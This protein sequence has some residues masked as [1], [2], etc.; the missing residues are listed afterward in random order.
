M[1]ATQ[2]CAHPF[3]SEVG[4]AQ[5]ADAAVILVALGSR[6]DV[7]PCVRLLCH[8]G[9]AGCP[10]AAHPP[11]AHLLH[12]CAHER[13][14]IWPRCSFHVVTH[15]A[16]AAWIATMLR[17]AAAHPDDAAAHAVHTHLLPIPVSLGCE[18]SVDEHT[19]GVPDNVRTA[20]ALRSHSRI[21]FDA[22]TALCQRLNAHGMHGNGLL[23]ANLFALET[24]LVAEM[25]ALPVAILS[26]YFMP[27]ALDADALER[28]LCHHRP[29]FLTLLQRG[30]TTQR[31][32]TDMR[33]RMH[34]PLA[35]RA[36]VGEDEAA[37]HDVDATAR[38][39]Q[40]SRTATMSWE[41]VCHWAYPLLHAP[42]WQHL[43]SPGMPCDASVWAVQEEE[44]EEEEE[45]ADVCLAC[46]PGAVCHC[47]PGADALMAALA[48]T[49]PYRIPVLYGCSQLLA[50]R[51][52]ALPPCAR[53]MGCWEL[54]A[55][56]PTRVAATEAAPARHRLLAVTFGSMAQ[57]G[58]FSSWHQAT[59]TT[60]RGDANQLTQAHVWAV[61]THLI[62]RA[63]RERRAHTLFLSHGCAAMARGFR[64]AAA[65][66]AQLLHL[67]TLQEADAARFQ[68][69]GVFNTATAVLHHVGVGTTH[70]ALAAGVH[71]VLAPCMFDQYERADV[72]VE[73]KL[74]PADAV[75]DMARVWTDACALCA[76]VQHTTDSALDRGV[77]HRKD[78][79][80]HFALT[81]QCEAVLSNTPAA[82]HAYPELCRLARAIVACFTPE[83]TC[84]VPLLPAAQAAVHALAHEL[85]SVATWTA[86]HDTFVTP[87]GSFRTFSGSWS[88][89][90]EDVPPLRALR[91]LPDTIRQKL[92]CCVLPNGTRALTTSAHEA[93]HLYRELVCDDVYRI[94]QLVERC[95][96][97]S[98]LRSVAAASLALVLDVGA[99]IG[100]LP[101]AIAHA[102]RLLHARAGGAQPS[103]CTA[104]CTTAL[105]A[106][107]PAR[108]HS[109]SASHAIHVLAVEPVSAAATLLEANMHLLGVPCTRSTLE[110]LPTAPTACGT[111]LHV[112]LL[113]CAAVGNTRVPHTGTSALTVH[114]VDADAT[115]SASRPATV[116][117][118][119]LPHLLSNCSVLAA[120]KLRQVRAQMTTA[121]A[122]H[123]SAGLLVEAVPAATLHDILAHWQP[124]RD[125]IASHT[126]AEHGKRTQPAVVELLKVDVEGLE[127]EALSSLTPAD[128]QRVLRV[129]AEGHPRT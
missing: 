52:A 122:A 2:S 34:P 26:P 93:L 15:A 108:M 33:S 98:T 51:P 117:I 112:T 115:S 110:E 66:D 71:Q 42:R 9:G 120:A 88:C 7:E 25:L 4:A 45:V 61:L 40:A 17:D 109:A 102:Q 54:P 5:Y 96:G 86:L 100:M 12:A 70:D 27:H 125:G 6:G 32:D 1:Q 43:Y 114:T 20:S 19:H 46:A 14:C 31:V 73:R 59:L 16:H 58:V 36:R 92:V 103:G 28:H 87:G 74:V 24:V 67:A 104:A 29:R 78:H 76:A 113:Q 56:E 22:V 38:V 111:T 124:L 10:A 48:G 128:W 35:K 18:S 83:L 85:G 84:Q 89:P 65:A 75:L 68:P 129:A 11:A 13:R 37:C 44:E 64:M 8:G 94:R 39:A 116:P 81:E 30:D 95:Q 126:I 105:D 50:P 121:A 107:P 118:M 82:V 57:V 90:V 60:V 49:L 77:S 23:L 3:L 99:N 106:A 72:C 41:D 91:T 55:T 119:V 47:Q 123:A 79:E 53:V 62:S 101:I 69:H 97:S 63:A 80:P 21:L 127:L